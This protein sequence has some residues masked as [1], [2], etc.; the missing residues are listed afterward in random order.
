MIQHVGGCTMFGRLVGP[1]WVA[2]AVAI[3]KSI[4][5]FM[6]SYEMCLVSQG[7]EGAGA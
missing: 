3:V 1:S 2:V 4:R 6:S 7:W 5:S